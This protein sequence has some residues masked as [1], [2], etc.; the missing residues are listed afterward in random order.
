MTVEDREESEFGDESIIQS[1]G[2][3]SSAIIIEKW[4]FLYK[5]RVLI[6]GS[7]FF[8]LIFF[9]DFFYGSLYLE[10]D[11]FPRCR[12]WRNFRKKEKKK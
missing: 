6:F 3:A 9:N 2:S 7:V 11:H 8:S 4:K 10:N 5:I 12:I 1:P